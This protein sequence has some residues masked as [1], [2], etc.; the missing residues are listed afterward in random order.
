MGFRIE[1]SKQLYVGST[2]KRLFCRTY[3]C[4]DIHLC[5]RRYMAHQPLNTDS[6]LYSSIPYHIFCTSAGVSVPLS[7]SCT[8]VI[9]STPCIHTLPWVSPFKHPCSAVDV[10]AIG[11]RVA[12]L[13]GF[14]KAEQDACGHCW[15]SK[16]CKKEQSYLMTRKMYVLYNVSTVQGTKR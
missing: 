3:G 4:R 7:I 5:Q 9:Q 10:R 16:C 8:N 14:E 6:L 2:V 13:H 15:V 12:C 1:H 11:V